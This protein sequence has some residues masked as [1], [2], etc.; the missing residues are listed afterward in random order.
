MLLRIA[1]IVVVTTVKVLRRIP[2]RSY[3]L[4]SASEI[5]LAAEAE[6][7]RMD[8]SLDA[9]LKMVASLLCAVTPEA[10]QALDWFREDKAMSSNRGRLAKACCSPARDALE[11]APL[12]TVV[13]DRF[14]ETC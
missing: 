12:P 4:N 10:Q 1:S 11:G 6:C 2:L 3:G 13:T 5:T 14:G 7:E 8:R 9:A